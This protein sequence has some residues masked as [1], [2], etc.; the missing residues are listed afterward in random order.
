MT[1]NNGT[2]LWKLW[3]YWYN[4]PILHPWHIT[5]ELQ[6]TADKALIQCTATNTSPLMHEWWTT[7]HKAL[8][9]YTDTSTAMHEWWT[10]SHKALIQRTDTSCLTH[11]WWSTRQKAPIQ[12]TYLYFILDSWM[13]NHKSLNTMYR[14][15]MLD[16]WIMKHKPE[17]S[18]TTL[19]GCTSFIHEWWTTS[20]KA[21]IHCTCSSSLLCE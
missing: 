13:M 7:S 14:Y 8:R 21:P 15:F 4:V 12:R 18:E 19:K 9:Q 16:A 6:A 11:E 20:H 17:G 1:N 10:T 5:D 2:K 3:L